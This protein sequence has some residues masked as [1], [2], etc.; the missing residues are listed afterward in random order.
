MNNGLPSRPLLISPPIL[1]VRRSARLKPSWR[2]RLLYS[3]ISLRGRHLD[4]YARIEEFSGAVASYR[5]LDALP[6]APAAVSPATR[7]AAVNNRPAEATSRPRNWLPQPAA[8]RL[9]YALIGHDS[10]FSALKDPIRI[11]VRAGPSGT[12]GTGITFAGR[13]L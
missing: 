6:A 10:D 11:S 12:V 2:L 5:F 13:G 1:P 7:R 3:S 9:P 4:S 8:A